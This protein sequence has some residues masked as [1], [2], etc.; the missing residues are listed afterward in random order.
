MLW[1]LGNSKSMITDMKYFL[2]TKNTFYIP[3]IS[4]TSKAGTL[5]AASEVPSFSPPPTLTKG[6]FS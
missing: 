1:F 2:K 4:N 5:K 3:S 6:K